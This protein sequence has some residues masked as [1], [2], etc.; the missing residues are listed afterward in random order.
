MGAIYFGDMAEDA[1]TNGTETLR[2]TSVMVDKHGY[3][4]M[5][6]LGTIPSVYYLPPVN[7]MF[8]VESGFEGLD[9][10]VSER[11]QAQPV[12]KDKSK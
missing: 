7:R 9:P 12:I 5:E 8:P 3:R 4:Y 6:E 1:I 10:S 2:F 11:Y